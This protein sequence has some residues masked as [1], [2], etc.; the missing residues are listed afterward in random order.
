M[1]K[2]GRWIRQPNFPNRG[3]I[4]LQVR[5]YALDNRF[6]GLLPE[7]FGNLGSAKMLK[8]SGSL[9]NV[10]YVPDI[11]RHGIFQRVL[12][13]KR[14][15]DHCSDTLFMVE[16]EPVFTKGRRAKEEHWKG[17]PESIKG[18]GFS[19]C[20]VERGGSVT[21]HGPGQVVGYPILRLR[22]FCPGPKAYVGM[23][24]EVVIRV[25]AEWKIQGSLRE[26]F[27]GVW[28]EGVGTPLKKIAA[29]GVHITHGITMH[30]WALNVNVDLNPFGFIRPCGI[31]GC[32]VT[33]MAQLHGEQVNI[34]E[35]RE[36]LAYH[37]A[38]VFGIEWKE[39][40]TM[41]PNLEPASLMAS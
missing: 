5:L 17:T 16:H 19:I 40:C 10:S 4:A 20:E 9:L 30:G 18:H 33:S 7:I 37:F 15:E 8:R 27:P 35:V 21:Y 36:Q 24:Q 29:I 3:R 31:E 28:V 6:S 25:L 38:D 22:D 2:A 1:A 26:K 41:L 34:L 13:Q 39:K 11:K 12:A 32:Q 23:L 14:V